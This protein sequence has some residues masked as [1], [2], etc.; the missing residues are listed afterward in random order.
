MLLVGFL[1][2]ANDAKKYLEDHDQILGFLQIIVLG[3]RFRRNVT[4]PLG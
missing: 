4:A 2:Q 3:L 1:A